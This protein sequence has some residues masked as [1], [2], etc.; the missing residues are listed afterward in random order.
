MRLVACALWLV[1]CQRTQEPAEPAGSAAG[2]SAGSASAGADPWRAAPADAAGPKKSRRERAE[3]A[4][5]R[6]NDIQPKLAKLRG[7]AFDHPVPTAYQ[8]TDDFRAFLHKEL[9]KE[10]PPEKSQKVSAAWLHI[11]LLA[12]PVDLAKAYEQTM[13]SQAA[14]YYDP[15]AK[16]FFVVMVPDSELMLDTMSAHELTHG[17]QD[18]RFDLQKYMSPKPPL[19]DDGAFARQFVVEGDATFAMLLYAAAAGSKS[20]VV[21][22]MV[23]KI[24]HGQVEQFASMDLAAYD[25]MMK[26]QAAAMPD[27][28][29]DLKQSMAAIGELP[30]AVVGPLLASYMKGAAA[31]LVAYD[32][33]GWPAV[34]AL[35]KDPP[36]STE[37]V[38]HPSSKL[39]P[40]RDHPHKI[41]LAKLPGEELTTNT[42]GELLWSVYFNLWVPE[43]AVD[44]SEG[45]G[46]DRYTVVKRPDGKLLAFLATTWDTPDDAKQ[47]ESAYQAS[48]AKRF[49]SHDRASM[50]SQARPTAVQTAGKNVFVLDGDDDAKLLDRLIR[51]TK[52]Q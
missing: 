24:M 2:G 18:Q 29:A 14:A 52:I 22:G 45:W 44:A 35:Y 25:K 10:L 27:M 48:I 12:K 16:K 50:G 28:D 43:H 30:P 51:E 13:T 49:P 26:S 6:V 31:V 21:K 38:L 39:F 42:L 34:D 3:E 36:E 47:F 15:G 19:D 32:R 37:Q 9:A 1:A 40:T 11:G 7:L 33:G 5:A 46:G 8:T 4:L 17:L 41:A 20:D 23:L